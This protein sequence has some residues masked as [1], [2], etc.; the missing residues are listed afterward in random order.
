[1][2]VLNKERYPAFESGT[3]NVRPKRLYINISA[4][5]TLPYCNANRDDNGMPKRREYG[6][7]VRMYISSQSWKKAMRAYFRDTCQAETAHTS[8]A[9]YRQLCEKLSEATGITEEAAGKY[10]LK[11]TK[12]TPAF[13]KEGTECSLY[14]MPKRLQE[15]FEYILRSYEESPQKAAADLKKGFRK[16]SSCLPSPTHIIYGRMLIDDKTMAEYDAPCQVADAFS[17]NGIRLEP[18]FFTAVADKEYAG[19]KGSAYMGIRLAASGTLYRYANINLSSG[20]ELYRYGALD[21]PAAC[22]EFLK[23]FVFASPTG[24][25]HSHGHTTLPSRL[26]VELREAPINYG[27]AFRNGIRTRGRRKPIGGYEEA[28]SIALD[29]YRDD[30]N[31]LCGTP[32]CTLE[33]GNMSLS[34]MQAALRE[35]IGRRIE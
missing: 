10:V 19:S 26:I 14:C 35:E 33:L 6:G 5:Q 2:P 24:M 12:G 8:T 17:V 27:P 31:E 7:L 11:F 16:Y 18:D 25:L 15:L 20:S 34:E 32:L 23:A 1:M 21:I 13:G 3:P 9:I 30:V 22:A 28:A 29:R 4:L